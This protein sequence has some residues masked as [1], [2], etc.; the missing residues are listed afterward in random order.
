MNE[1]P[2]ADQTNVSAHLPR[3]A[4]ADSFI[5]YRIETSHRVVVT[6]PVT[7]SSPAGH[8][9]DVD[10]MVCLP[11]PTIHTTSTPP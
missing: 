5:S 4:A 9:R 7:G 10:I 11:G 3:I 1:P 8:V 6:D 2:Q